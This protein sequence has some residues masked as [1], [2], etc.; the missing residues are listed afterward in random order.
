MGRRLKDMPAGTLATLQGPSIAEWSPVEPGG[1]AT[2]AR[3]FLLCCHQVGTSRNPPD[4]RS[5]GLLARMPSELGSL[6]R[7]RA[8][9]LLGQ[10]LGQN[11][12]SFDLTGSGVADDPPPRTARGH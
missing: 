7:R 5:T 2:G 10:L 12:A 6:A 8:Q 3:Q 9:L 11:S 1:G 4:S